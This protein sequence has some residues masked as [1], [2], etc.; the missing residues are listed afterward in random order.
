MLTYISVE[1]ALKTCAP[2]AH[3]RQNL[4]ESL[5]PLEEDSSQG[6]W[7]ASAETRDVLT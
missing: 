6:L 2:G 1:E 7:L 3:P 5:E 4:K